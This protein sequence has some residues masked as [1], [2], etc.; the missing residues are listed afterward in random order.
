MP[1]A[2]KRVNRS[3]TGPAEPDLLIVARDQP[4]LF[5]ALLQEFWG[6]PQLRILLDGRC[7]D[8]RRYAGAVPVDR[9]RGGS[10]GA[11][12]VLRRISSNGSILWS[13]RPP[14]GTRTDAS[15]RADHS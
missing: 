3:P 2:T 13:A 14:A 9:R 12:C 11:P 1:V 7:A 5:R 10:G 4:K 6:S 15:P 8:R